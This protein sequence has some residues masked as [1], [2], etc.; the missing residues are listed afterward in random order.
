MP[1]LFRPLLTLALAAALLAPGA[2]T[3]QNEEDRRLSPVGIA[4]THVGDAYVKVTYGRPYM[5]DRQIFGPDTT[6]L[7]PFDRLWRTG[8]NEA[9]ELT[10]TG[11]IRVGGTLLDAGTYSLFTVPGASSW[12]VHVSPQLGL[13]GTGRLDPAT[14]E[15]T[16][17]VYDPD[18]NVASFS[19]EPSRTDE[20][21]DPFTMMF[22]P[23]DT[24]ADLVLRWER[25]EV[26]IPVRPPEA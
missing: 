5:R 20:P 13:D 22:E 15:F 1:R 3:A 9:T 14:G 6:H 8:A 23:A 21:V 7:V 17:N 19:V 25:T 2:A 26:R 16:P 4:R 10:I 11:P 12:E 24:G 18:R